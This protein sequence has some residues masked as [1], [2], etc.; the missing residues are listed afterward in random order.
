MYRIFKE[1]PRSMVETTCRPE[2]TP[3]SCRQ[4][5]WVEWWTTRMGFTRSFLLCSGQAELKCPYLWSTPV[6]GSEFFRT[7]RKRNQTGSISRASSVQEEF[8][9]LQSVT[10]VFLG[11]FLCATL[12]ISIPENP[13]SASN[14]RSS[15]AVAELT[16][17]RADT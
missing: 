16:I 6:K 8:L 17:S 11:V 12:R 3:L 9:K 2:S 15:L 13:G 10:C 14:Q 5:L 7:Y 1:S 4:G